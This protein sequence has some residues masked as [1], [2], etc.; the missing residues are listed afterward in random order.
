ME[1]SKYE[2]FKETTQKLEERLLFG[3]YPE[4][5]QYPDWNDKINY[6]KEI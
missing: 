5:E 6:L 4:L 3:C 1:F 2:N